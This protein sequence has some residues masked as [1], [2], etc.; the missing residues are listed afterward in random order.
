M[1]IF[2]VGSV[3][4]LDKSKRFG[5]SDASYSS[6]EDDV[7]VEEWFVISVDL[8]DSCQFHS[9]FFVEYKYGEYIFFCLA[10][11]NIY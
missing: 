7:R 5:I 10:Y 11:A 6:V 4:E 9:M 1:N 2:E 8:R 3:I